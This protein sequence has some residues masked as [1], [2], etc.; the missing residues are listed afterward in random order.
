MLSINNA[1]LNQ[2]SCYLVLGIQPAPNPPQ[3]RDITPVT[4]VNYLAQPSYNFW[5]ASAVCGFQVGELDESNN[6]VYPGVPDGALSGGYGIMATCNGSYC[7]P[8][9]VQADIRYA[10]YVDD[11]CNAAY[12]RAP[13]F[14]GEG[15][16]GGTGPLYNR[17]VP[18]QE[19]CYAPFF[20]IPQINAN[21]FVQE[22][23][24]QCELMGM[25][26]AGP[27]QDACQRRLQDQPC[28][29]GWIY[30]GEYC[31]YKFNP[32][33][34][35]KYIVVDSEGQAACDSIPWAAATP[36]TA[37]TTAADFNVEVLTS[38]NIDQRAWLQEYF[39]LWNPA[40]SNRLPSGS[41][42]RIPIPG[43]TNCYCL[44]Y[45]PGVGGQVRFR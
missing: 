36:T 22:R 28:R 19:R 14:F 10:D 32:A 43:A 6:L 35:T 25:N 9:E 2:T 41:P 45:L 31:F 39:I 13:T 17:F 5:Y 27:T 34:D 42:Y 1:T 26:T 3:L 24:R 37:A 40:G 23:Q 15:F 38:A 29:R 44:D 30:F 20:S 8:V 21:N 16:G 12:P 33:T 11:T 4:S 7:V 18:A